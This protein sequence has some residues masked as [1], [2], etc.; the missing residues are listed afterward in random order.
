MACNCKKLQVTEIKRDDVKIMM[1]NPNQ[2]QHNHQ[3]GQQTLHQILFGGGELPTDENLLLFINVN[4]IGQNDI[5]E[6]LRFFLSNNNPYIHYLNLEET[7]ILRLRLLQDLEL[8]V[9]SL[10]ESNMNYDRIMND[11]IF[12][13]DENFNEILLEYAYRVFQPIQEGSSTEDSEGNN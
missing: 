1:E 13:N 6:A 5:W 4:N 7:N 11:V 8:L 2:L 10:F 12:G 3:P 9:E